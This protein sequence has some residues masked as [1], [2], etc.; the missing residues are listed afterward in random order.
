LTADFENSPQ[1]QQ[2]ILSAARLDSSQYEEYI[3]KTVSVYFKYATL[4]HHWGKDEPQLRDVRGRVIYQ[5]DPTDGIMKLRSFCA[6]AR[7]HGYLWAWSDTCC[8]D[9]YSTVELARVIAPMFLWYCHSA[10]TIVYLT[11]VMVLDGCPAV[12]GS[13]VVGLF[14]NFLHLGLCCST[15][16]TSRSIGNTHLRTTRR[17]ALCFASWKMRRG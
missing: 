13:N 12:S 16:M 10:L 11:D 3:H 4:S 7:K 14:K 6:T 1:F 2:L 5:L 15:R 17:I 8:I 9:K